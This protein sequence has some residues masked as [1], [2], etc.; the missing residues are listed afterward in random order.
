MVE[1]WEGHRYEVAS[2]TKE[3]PEQGIEVARAL[4]RE[5]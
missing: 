2:I 4:C 3:R 5:P 1:D